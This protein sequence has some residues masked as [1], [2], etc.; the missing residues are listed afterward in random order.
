MRTI[1]HFAIAAIVG[2]HTPNATASEFTLSMM[3][4]LPDN[5]ELDQVNQYYVEKWNQS[6]SNDSPLETFHTSIGEIKFTKN[7]FSFLY[8]SSPRLLAWLR[9]GKSGSVENVNIIK[10]WLRD[11]AQAK[12]RLGYVHKYSDTQPSDYGEYTE[13]YYQKGDLYFKTYFQYDRVLETYGRHSLRYTY[14][15][16]VGSIGRKRHYEL[17]QYRQKLG[18]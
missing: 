3:S 2:L 10:A 11:A 5:F 16:E 8:V 14:F 7:D 6:T 18:S 13:S 1:T 4:R 17:E 15:V 12:T 9:I